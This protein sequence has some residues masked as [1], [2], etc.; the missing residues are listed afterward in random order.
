VVPVLLYLATGFNQVLNGL[1]LSM[2]MLVS[3]LAMSRRQA[4][5]PAASRRRSRSPTNDTG[6]TR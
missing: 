3:C 2:L 5:P 6:D 1:Y 4:L